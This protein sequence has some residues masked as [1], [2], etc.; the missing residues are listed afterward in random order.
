MASFN[1]IVKQS[2]L[3][4]AKGQ[5]GIEGSLGITFEKDA[6]FN[7]VK[8]NKILKALGIKPNPRRLRKE[9]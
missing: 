8:T 7:E 9:T 5:E 4:E 6:D 1:Q 2:K 3:P